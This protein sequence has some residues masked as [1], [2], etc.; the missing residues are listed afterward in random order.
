KE[1]RHARRR[2]RY[3]R[4][5]PLSSQVFVARQ[6]S[7]PTQPGRNGNAVDIA[8][9][10]ADEDRVVDDHRPAGRQRHRLGSG[11]RATDAAFA[12]RLVIGVTRYAPRSG[13][14]DMQIALRVTE[15]HASVG[16]RRRPLDRCI[17]PVFPNLFARSHIKAEE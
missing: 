4:G 6:P 1:L 11:D 16:D 9:L 10:T 12:Y 17:D 2:A 15:I 3:F 7:L 5:W 14:Q 13:I 8:V